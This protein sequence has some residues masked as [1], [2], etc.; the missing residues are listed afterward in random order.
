MGLD[1]K[2]VASAR[3]ETVLAESPLFLTLI[4]AVCGAVAG[5]LVPLLAHG[6]VRLRWVPFRGLVKLVTSVPEPG[7]TLGGAGVGA[8]LG[9]LVG[10]RGAQV[11]GGA[12][13]RRTDRPGG[14]G[15]LPGVAALGRRLGAPRRQGAGATRPR[16]HGTRR[17]EE[18]LSWSRLAEALTAHGHRW[19]PEDPLCG[20]RHRLGPRHGRPAI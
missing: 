8:L 13:H 3:D 7:L 17:R 4:C 18:R 2:L 10:L 14:P 6:V 16:R 12:D 11:A 5:A 19:Q 15:R 20:A 9:L 1:K